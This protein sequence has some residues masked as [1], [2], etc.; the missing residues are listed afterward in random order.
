MVCKTARAN[1][2]KTINVKAIEI[3]L[4]ILDVHKTKCIFYKLED[5]DSVFDNNR[6]ATNAT[7]VGIYKVLTIIS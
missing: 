3:V 1:E 4:F 6:Q 7:T 2:F 5:E